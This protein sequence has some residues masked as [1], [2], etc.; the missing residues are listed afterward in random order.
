MTDEITPTREAPA[1]IDVQALL[2]QAVARGDVLPVEFME[3]LTALEERLDQRK[4]DSE[5]KRAIAAAIHEIPT[6]IASD[7]RKQSSKRVTDDGRTVVVKGY[8]KLH[9]IQEVADPI[10]ASHGLSYRWDRGER[11]AS[12]NRDVLFIVEHENGTE[13]VR[14]RMS[15]A[16]DP[17][18]KNREGRPIRPQIQDIGSGDSY[19]ARYTLVRGLKIRIKDEDDDGEGTEACEPISDE[20]ALKLEAALNDSGWGEAG[21]RRF[22]DWARVDDHRKLP[23][24]RYADAMNR[25]RRGKRKAGTA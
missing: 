8:A 1:A 3:R 20:Q 7:E 16:V 2:E 23:E 24:S 10:L 25:I 19:V 17:A 4:R 21:W 15:D 6:I 13:E 5:R 12:G 22:L 14:S 11:D 18:A 9:R